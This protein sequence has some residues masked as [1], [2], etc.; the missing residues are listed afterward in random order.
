[1][2]REPGAYQK[3]VLAKLEAT[4]GVAPQGRLAGARFVGSGRISY[5]KEYLPPNTFVVISSLADPD[6]LLEI[7]AVAAL[8][9]E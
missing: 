7:N 9:E 3:A 4:T 8:P 1:L 5:C 6:F 2:Q